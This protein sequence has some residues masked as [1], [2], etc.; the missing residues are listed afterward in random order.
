MVSR[1]KRR[2]E[3]F[4]IGLLFVIAGLALMA[5]YVCVAGEGTEDMTAEEDDQVERSRL[6]CLLITLPTGVIAGAGALFLDRRKA[7]RRV[8][9][10][11]RWHGDWS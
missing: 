11:S 5:T 4:A 3:N 8:R 6:I 2:M 10:Y 9:E 1:R 7:R